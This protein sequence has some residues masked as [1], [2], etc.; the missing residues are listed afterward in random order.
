MIEDGIANG[1][2]PNEAR[3]AAMRAMDEMEQRKKEM[4]DMRLLPLP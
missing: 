4:R 2:S 3:Y 1:L